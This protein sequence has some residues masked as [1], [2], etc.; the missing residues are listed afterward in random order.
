MIFEVHKSCDYYTASTRLHK[1]NIIIYIVYKL[2][3]IVMNDQTF[4]V[5]LVEHLI[6][7]LIIQPNIFFTTKIFYNQNYII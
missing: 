1:R 5:I 6:I 2:H 7:I 3:H 4:I